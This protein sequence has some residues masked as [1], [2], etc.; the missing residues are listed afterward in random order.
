MN[1][2]SALL[3]GFVATVFLTGIMAGSQGIG[4]TRMNIPYMLGT[5][6][7]TDRDRARLYGMLFHFLNG[8]LFAAIYVFAFESWGRA[9]WWLGAVIGLVQAL[10]VLTAAMMMLPGMHPRMAGEQRG[11]TPTRQL[12]PPGFFALN[13]G[14]RTPASIILAHLV[15]GAILGAFYTL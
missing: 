6:F 12:E 13:Y 1:W 3:W 2:G 14:A 11:P 10:F 5:I 8:W 9:E 15:Y 4:L 7:T